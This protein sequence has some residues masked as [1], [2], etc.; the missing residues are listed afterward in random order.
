LNEFFIVA[1]KPKNISDHEYEYRFLERHWRLS[2]QEQER[3]LIADK[4]RLKPVG[5]LLKK[6]K[7]RQQHD[8]IASYYIKT[9]LLFMVE[10]RNDDFWQQSLSRVFFGY[11]GNL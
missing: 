7:K 2:F 4:G 11:F 10:K 3:K 5:R 6:M 9:V 8:K 1:K